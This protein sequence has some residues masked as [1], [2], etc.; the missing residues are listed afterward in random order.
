MS[1]IVNSIAPAAHSDSQPLYI[2]EQ[3][4]NIVQ[5]LWKMSGYERG[6]FSDFYA[7]SHA[8][9]R[10]DVYYRVLGRV[11]RMCEF[12]HMEAHLI[13]RCFY[14]PD[15]THRFECLMDQDEQL[16][17]A[18]MPNEI[19]LFRGVVDPAHVGWSWTT[20]RA[21]AEWFASRWGRNSTVL[22]G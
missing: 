1:T 13:S 2:D 21:V 5:T 11:H 16:A 6:S 18:G 12:P 15:R 9:C 19:A 20:D 7:I 10:D 8:I 3:H 17:L 22:I 14:P 4:E